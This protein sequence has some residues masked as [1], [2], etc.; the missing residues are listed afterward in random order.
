MRPDPLTIEP[1]PHIFW[2]GGGSLG[3]VVGGSRGPRLLFLFYMNVS[4]I[5]L[6]SLLDPQVLRVRWSIPLVLPW[7]TASHF[8]HC[9]NREAELKPSTFSSPTFLCFPVFPP[10][11]TPPPPPVI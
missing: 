9:G 11:L 8:I 10:L 4:G 1:R 3:S 5:G 2:W 6:H 7:V